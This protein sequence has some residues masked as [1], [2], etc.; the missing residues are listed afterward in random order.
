MD[1]KNFDKFIEKVDADISKHFESELKKLRK[2][3]LKT[4]RLKT[5][6]DTGR[7]R[8]SWKVV[9]LNSNS[10]KVMNNTNYAIHVEYPHRKRGG[11]GIVEGQYMLRDTFQELKQEMPNILT[12]I[13]KE[14]WT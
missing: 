12:N 9:P 14:E 3:A 10:I 11:K 5:P 7:L 13:L 2:K 8:R 1:L 4:A 6:V